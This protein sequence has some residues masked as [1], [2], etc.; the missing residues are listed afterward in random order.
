MHLSGTRLNGG[1]VEPPR[2]LALRRLVAALLSGSGPGGRTAVDNFAQAQ[3]GRRMAMGLDQGQKES[4]T[5]TLLEGQLLV[6][7]PE[8]CAWGLSSTPIH[9]HHA[10][11][12]A[13]IVSGMRRSLATGELVD[14]VLEVRHQAA[15]PPA[16]RA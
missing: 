5:P 8:W 11:D 6:G 4:A 2:E 1:A 14:V 10:Q 12:G 16:P 3:I 7:C 13:E 15:P 9:F